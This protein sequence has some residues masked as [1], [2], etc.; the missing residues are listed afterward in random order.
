MANTINI[1]RSHL[2]LALCL[3]LAVLVGYFLA[4]PL[5]SGSMAVVL[6]VISVLTVP[7]LIKWHHPMLV[8]SWNAIIAPTFLPGQPFVWMLMAGTSLLFA[9]LNRSV[10]SSN[11]F[12]Y[13]SSL[14]KPILF[15]G[16]VVVATA[17]LNGGLGLR[18]LG[19]EHY[20]SRNYLYILAAIMGYFA[21][22]SVRIPVEKS[23]LYL[24]MF[25]LPAL[26]GLIPNL[27]YN[28]GRSWYFLFS[29]FPSSSVMEQ[30][31]GDTALDP[32]IVRVTGFSFVGPCLYAFVL[33]LYGIRGILDTSK[34][35]RGVL[36]ALAAAA[37]L[38]SGFRS[39]LILFALTFAA[40]FYLEGLHRTKLLPA[41]LG[42]ALLCGAIVLPMT[43]KLPLVVQRTLS[44]LPTRV[45]PIVERATVDS[46]AWRV[47]LWK[48][49]LPEIPDHLIKGK[50]YSLDPNEMYMAQEDARRHAGDPFR[51]S[52]LCGDYHN[53]PLSV[54][55]PLG[56]FGVFGFLWLLVAGVRYLLLNY[57]M[58]DPGLKEINTFLLGA[59]VAKIIF[60]MAVFGSLYSDL[61]FF[62]G[63][64][65]MSVSLNGAPEPQIEEET[66]E[67]AIEAFS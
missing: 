14:V 12:I 41:M 59:F 40:V 24:A 27:V 10:N 60:F 32:G 47:E 53:G 62:T 1:P 25:F 64:L 30:V 15:L 29:F 56:L 5:D 11:Q 43:E 49:V 66:T 20:G 23:K 42:C 52:L 37:C 39:I 33:A 18:S 50:G 54:I 38:M 17:M 31:T 22:T 55:V 4:E 34:P 45:D 9:L 26:T 6:L 63:I 46:T 44:F 51:G 7:V 2:I 8:L 61:C 13:V 35:W 28:A 57:R 16:G 58:G 67:E 3:P 65:G 48:R 21:F 19:A 36:F